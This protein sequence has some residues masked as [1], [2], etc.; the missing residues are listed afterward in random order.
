MLQIA[1]ALINGSGLCRRLGEPR[2]GG[3][4]E[5]IHLAEEIITDTSAWPLRDFLDHD[6]PETCATSCYACIQQFQNRRYHGILDWRLGLAYLRAMLQPNFTC[7][8]DGEFDSFPELRGWQARARSLAENVAAMRPTSL[9]A[10]TVGPYHLPCI[11]SIGQGGNILGRT[12]VVHPMWRMDRGAGLRFLGNLPGPQLHFV[13][14]FDLERRPL[15]A[16]EMA[17]S[18][19]PSPDSQ[20]AELTEAT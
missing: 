13:D 1:D 17:L 8:L 5:I 9:R 11:A 4:P 14:T 19:E 2:S 7:G 18:R 20:V 6:H 16:L 3:R 10:E 12:V 15:R